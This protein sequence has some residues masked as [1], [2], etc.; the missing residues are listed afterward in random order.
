MMIMKLDE[1][2]AKLFVSNGGAASLLS[3]GSL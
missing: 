1:V 2:L 3:F